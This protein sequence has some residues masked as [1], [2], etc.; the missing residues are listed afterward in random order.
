MHRHYYPST[1]SDWEEKVKLI[2]KLKNARNYEP[3][4]INKI[5]KLMNGILKHVDIINSLGFEQYNTLHN[6]NLEKIDFGIEFS[7]KEI[8]P[9]FHLP[10]GFTYLNN[11]VLE[12]DWKDYNY[13]DEDKKKILNK[14]FKNLMRIYPKFIFAHKILDTNIDNIRSQINIFYPEF[15]KAFCSHSN[16]F[17]KGYNIDDEIQELLFYMYKFEDGKVFLD[18]ESKKPGDIE[19]YDKFMHD[20]DEDKIGEYFYNKIP[21]EGPTVLRTVILSSFD[22]K[23]LEII[24]DIKREYNIT[25]D[26]LLNDRE[27]QPEFFS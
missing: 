24:K 4:K 13:K 17:K 9:I 16:C 6:D 8:D 12:I 22:P 3:D 26:Q 1:H 23:I 7:E 5:D 27:I 14:K 11:N 18:Y 25:D 2:R 20:E 21:Y 15:D 19:K 10:Y